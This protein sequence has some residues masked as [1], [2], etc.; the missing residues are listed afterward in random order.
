MKMDSILT[1]NEAVH[2]FINNKNVNIYVVDLIH[3]KYNSIS[4]L[5]MN[6]IKHNK[7]LIFVQGCDE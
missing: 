4:E 1:L 6:E 2:T 3:N 7:N 5:T